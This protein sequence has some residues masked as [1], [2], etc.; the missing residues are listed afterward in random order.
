[1]H[2]LQNRPRHAQ[3]KINLTQKAWLWEQLIPVARFAFL[4]LWVKEQ[5]KRSY[6]NIK[7]PFKEPTFKTWQQ[8]TWLLKTGYIAQVKPI[9][10]WEG[11]RNAVK[12]AGKATVD[13]VSV[14][15]IDIIDINMQMAHLCVWVIILTKCVFVW[16]HHCIL[17]IILVSSE[18]AVYTDESQFTMFWISEKKS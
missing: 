4:V 1:M 12:K 15:V 17:L 5:K 18:F 7:L 10:Q 6:W 13:P 11:A 9:D 14:I 16:F 8:R 2:L 3:S